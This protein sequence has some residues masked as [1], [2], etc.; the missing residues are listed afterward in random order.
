MQL[1]GL[2][3]QELLLAIIIAYPN[4][5]DLKRMVSFELEENL[6]AIAG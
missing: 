2:Q 3:R 4:E 1:T 5:A 6:N